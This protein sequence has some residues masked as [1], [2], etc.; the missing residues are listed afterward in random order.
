MF[1][2]TL[3]VY[4]EISADYRKR[5]YFEK[6]DCAKIL[7]TYD[8]ICKTAIK[9]FKWKIVNPHLFFDVLLVSISDKLE[10]FSYKRNNYRCKTINLS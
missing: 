8:L 4:N 7:L 10:R 3:K 5:I 2:L 6:L 9:I 1:L